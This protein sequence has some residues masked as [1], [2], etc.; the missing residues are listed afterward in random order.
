MKNKSKQFE[1]MLSMKKSNLDNLQKQPKSKID[2]EYN[3][4]S[5]QFDE[6]IS[7]SDYRKKLDLLLAAATEMIVKQKG[8]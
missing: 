3:L 4:Y 5:K 6:N 8:Q 7:S 2:L 1:K